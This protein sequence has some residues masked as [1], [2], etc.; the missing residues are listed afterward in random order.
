MDADVL[1]PKAVLDA[2]R[3][4]HKAAVSGAGVEACPWARAV[5][6]ADRAAREAWVR[7]YAAGRT[8]LRSG[9]TAGQRH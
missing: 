9:G 1:G 5:T 7:G 4:G 6:P 2:Q 8:D 3:Q